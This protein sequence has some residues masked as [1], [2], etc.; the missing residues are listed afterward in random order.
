[1]LGQH[2]ELFFTINWHILEVIL[3]FPKNIFSNPQVL[4]SLHSTYLFSC[5][6]EAIY[7]QT[8]NKE[9]LG[10]TKQPDSTSYDLTRYAIKSLSLST[11]S[12]VFK[13]GEKHICRI[14][15]LMT[16]FSLHLIRLFTKQLI[17]A[18]IM[19]HHVSKKQLTYLIYSLD[20]KITN[21]M[22]CT[23]CHDVYTNSV[24]IVHSLWDKNDCW[25]DWTT[26]LGKINNLIQSSKKIQEAR[27]LS[28]AEMK[29]IQITV[30]K[31]C[32][33]L[34]GG[35]EVTAVTKQRHQKER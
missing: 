32:K 34:A 35:C 3:K 14:F 28:I 5:N 24:Q 33:K 4:H 15:S 11:L 9:K 20:L 17:L 23:L 31:N 12:F 16:A 27:L 6:R 7:W 13:N 1:M 29:R 19:I 10:N 2:T 8:K 22:I 26:F 18:Y 25:T 21:H 30:K